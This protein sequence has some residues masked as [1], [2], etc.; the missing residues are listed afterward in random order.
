MN[1]VQV[2]HRFFHRFF[3]KKYTENPSL[4]E[5]YKEWE[6]LSP[7]EKSELASTYLL[8][9]ET[10]LLK[11]D[12]KALQLFEAA[13]ILDSTNAELWHRQGL[14]FFEYGM[15]KGKE[16]SLLVANK[17]FK[18]A[19]SIDPEMGQSWHAWGNVL[20]ELGKFYGEHHYFLEAKEKLQKA[21][22]IEHD[23]LSDLYWDYALI[24]VQIAEHSGEAVDVRM[25]IEAFLTAEGHMERTFPEF[26][27][28]F[29]NAYLQLGLLINDSRLISLA[30]EQFKKT[31][32]IL[33][34][35]EVWSSLA[36]AYTELYINTMDEGNFS[37]ANEAYEEAINHNPKD[38][39]T[40]L[41]WSQL[42]GESGKLN[43]DVKKLRQ[44]IDK[45]VKA[46][47]L[48]PDD[49]EVV[50]Q[51]VESLSYLGAYTSRLDLLIEAE[52][53]VLLAID[54][55][56]DDPNLWYSYGICLGCFGHYY[57]DVEYYDLAIEKIQHGLTIDKNHA[58]LWHAL[59]SC[60]GEIGKMLDDPDM[61]EHASRFY[62]RACEL[63]PL[64][65]ALTFDHA[66][67]LMKL[68]EFLNDQKLLEESLH[69]FEITL[70]N[71]KDAL[72]YHPNWL[73][74]YASA[75]DLM[76]DFKEEESFYIRAVEVLQHV[77][78]IDPD[79]PRI[80]FR[81]GVCF[82]HLA[83]LTLEN[84]FFQRA[85]NYFR[86]AAI[87]DEEDSQLWLEWGLSLIFSAHQSFDVESTRAIYQ[88]AEQKI[89]RAGQLGNQQAYYHLAC[90]YSLMERYSESFA[91][92]EK[93]QKLD[94][95]PSLEEILEDDWLEGLRATQEFSHFISILEKNR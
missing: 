13:S 70:N 59:A 36:H 79:F 9:G 53:K 17:N 85:I 51:W 39:D 63:K 22:S 93:A 44:S 68:A 28:D 48:V 11:G 60:H 29:G 38:G 15:E 2:L 76:A 16:N 55:F 94:V 73:F 18:M 25:A 34:N 14:A 86:L 26:C 43:K 80:Q 91:L 31:A 33:P 30:V 58:E 8:E 77:L 32:Q 7:A 67:C 42:L 6:K 83:E 35:P 62:A 47:S 71:Q 5:S 57:E 88:E 72:L 37:K 95:L 19:T 45:C 49:P 50:G 89:I 20:F 10:Y 54:T 92:I 75:L 84:S 27:Q 82:S 81:I 23:S 56:G 66:V 65:P 12:L 41:H 1:Q 61:L 46:Q 4:S 87:Q 21:I 69:Q 64:C 24:W 74:E 40:W 52:D 78:L 3:P 90:L